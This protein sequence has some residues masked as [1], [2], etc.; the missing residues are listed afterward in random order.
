MKRVV[1]VA[2]LLV[3]LTGCL[4]SWVGRPVAQ[5]EREFGRPRNIQNN[6]DY[7]VY[8]YPDPLAPGQQMRF[9]VNQRGIVTDWS[10]TPDVPGVFGETIGVGDTNPPVVPTQ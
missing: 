4:H 2:G 8:I 3:V 9:W 1:F 5:L 6:G 10:A 7:R